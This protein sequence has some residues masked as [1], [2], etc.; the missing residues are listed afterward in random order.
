MTTE[1]RRTP[2]SS[3]RKRRREPRL[4]PTGKG[5]TQARSEP[6]GAEQAETNPAPKAAT[7][8]RD[9]RGSSGKRRSE[10]RTG[11][12]SEAG[13]PKRK[14]MAV[15]RG[16]RRGR[17]AR[18]P[19]FGEGDPAAAEREP[20]A[21]SLYRDWREGAAGCRKLKAASSRGSV[22]AL[23]EQ[24]TTPPVSPDSIDSASTWR[25]VAPLLRR[26]RRRPAG[27][28]EWDQ[29]SAFFFFLAAFGLSAAASSLAS[30]W[31]LR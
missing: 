29:L 23:H 7:T 13:R 31:V 28:R 19:C 3:R 1:P 18:C 27:R 10:D 16:P 6:K 26:Q 4:E 24:L 25:C 11:R 20:E 22:R 14:L 17:T 30:D 15:R 9:L 21:L 5:G 2:C 8:A 12:T